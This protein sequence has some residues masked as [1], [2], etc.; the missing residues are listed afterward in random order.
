MT[1]TPDPGP[2][3]RFT[4]PR[5][6]CPHPE[7]WTSDDDDS[8]EY[9]VSELVAGF[10]RALQPDTVLET[11]TAFGQTAQLI[12]EAL[13]KNGQ[14]RLV[15]LEP[16]PVRAEYS[17]NRCT[18]LPVEVLEVKSLDYTPDEELQF[19]WLDS[20]IHLRAQEARRFK[21]WFR[22]GTL[23]GFHDAGPHHALRPTLAPLWR[24]GWIRP[25]FLPTP[26]GVVFAEVTSI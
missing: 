2:E 26:R 7:R 11:G 10:V 16:D 20:L 24:E 17:R 3:S 22:A 1:Y 8:T 6:D 23:I 13:V 12:G 4:A 5:V 18:G 14:G 25:V 9:E 21:P 15:S 19:V